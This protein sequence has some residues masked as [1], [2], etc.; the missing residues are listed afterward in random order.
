MQ[1][2]QETELG[3]GLPQ[4]AATGNEHE[5][6]VGGVVLAQVVVV[7]VTDEL[8]AHTSRDLPV[9]HGELVLVM[10]GPRGGG[11][12]ESSTGEGLMV[13]GASWPATMS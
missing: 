11:A 10:G 6:V 1:A 8:G 13:M 9:A 3:R 5:G 2:G 4:D 7:M 12:V